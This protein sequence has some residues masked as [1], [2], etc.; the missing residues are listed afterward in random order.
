[1]MAGFMAMMKPTEGY[2]PR[3]ALVDFGEAAYAEQA[4]QEGAIPDQIQLLKA[5]E[6]NPE[7]LKSMRKLNAEASDPLADASALASLK[8]LLL[9]DLYGKDNYDEDSI[10]IDKST[11]LEISDLELLQLYKDAGGDYTTVRAR[12]A[13]EAE[14]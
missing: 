8:D 13:A 7:L 3:N 10:I 4:R 11:E 9:T 12:I 1:M 6:K 2:V 14:V 5:I